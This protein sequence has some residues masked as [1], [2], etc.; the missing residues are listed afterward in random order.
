VPLSEVF[1]LNKGVKEGYPL[2]GGYFTAAGSHSIKTVTNGYRH[3]AYH[4]KYW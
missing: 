3:A 4:Y 1:P 2:K